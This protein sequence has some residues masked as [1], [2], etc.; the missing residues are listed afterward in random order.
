M[1]N[2][3]KKVFN[4]LLDYIAYVILAVLGIG[5]FNALYLLWFTDSGR[6]ILSIF[7]SISVISWSIIRLLKKRT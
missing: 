4:V 3:I 1:F 5:I 6:I 2:M 7:I